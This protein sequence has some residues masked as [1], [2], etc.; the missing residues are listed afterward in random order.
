MDRTRNLSIISA[1]LVL[2][3]GACAEFFDIAWGTGSA[4]GRMSVTWAALF[5]AFLLLC[6][7]LLF[8]AHSLLWNDALFTQTARRWVGVRRQFGWVRRVMAAVIFVLPAWLLQF[9]IL[10]ILFQGFFLRLGLWVFALVSVSFLIA[11]EDHLFLPWDRFFFLA[12]FSSALFAILASLKSVTAYPFSLSWSEG[13]RIWDYSTLFGSNRYQTQAG[14]EISVFLDLGRQIVGG[15]PFLFPGLTLQ[16]ERLWLGIVAIVPYFL[17]GMAAFR[18]TFHK[19]RV[20]LAAVLWTFIFLRQGPIG[21]PLLWCAILV[22]LAWKSGLMLSLPLVIFA[23]RAAYISRFTW[24][25]AP[26]IWFFMLELFDGLRTAETKLHLTQRAR[27]LSLFLVFG[28]LGALLTLGLSLGAYFHLEWAQNLPGIFLDLTSAFG[29]ASQQPL[30]WYRLL[31]NKTYDS[32]ILLG[33]AIATL[34][35]AAVLAY[36]VNNGRSINHWQKCI[37]AL[38]LLVFFLVGLVI[39]A[40]IGGGGDLHNMDMFLVGLF[41]AAVLIVCQ[42]GGLIQNPRSAPFRVRMM[43]ILLV[44]V[45]GIQPLLELRSYEFGAQASWLATL[46][47]APNARALEMVPP[48]GVIEKSLAVI[49]AAA[50]A[51]KQN[52]GVLFMDQRQLLTFGYIQDIPLISLYD[53][54]VLMDQALASN[55]PYFQGFYADLSAKR[56]SLIVTQPLVVKSQGADEFGEE[57]NAWVKW[58]T[59]PL[60][61]FYDVKQTLTDVNVQLLIPKTGE[62]NC[63]VPRGQ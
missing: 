37:L 12:L 41:L 1:L 63:K 2:L 14:Q 35:L 8:A 50:D 9:T 61:C 6:L 11:E 29:R 52:G 5:L 7:S 45:P 62:V 24:V 32:G 3:S 60:L 54:K 36:Q 49:Q 59:Q 58:V 51:A 31:P 10:G 48:Q 44:M 30:L 13:N 55:E 57:N 42:Q 40:K 46:T 39:S 47:D 20:W 34:P 43:L 22:L 4:L 33:T 23:T 56:F 16:Q 25:F 27:F 19:K 38:P 28:G 53:K 17:L 18:S 21:T 26:G 15:I